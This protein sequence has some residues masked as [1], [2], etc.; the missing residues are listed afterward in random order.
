MNKP[1]ECPP[2]QPRLSDVEL[3]RSALDGKLKA[4]AGYDDILWK[5]R[6]GY[7][8]ILYGSLALIIGTEGLP[9]QAIARDFRSPLS[10][11]ILIIGFS[12]AAFFVDFGYLRKKLKVVVLTNSLISKASGSVSWNCKPSLESH[13]HISGE[14]NIKNSEFFPR[15]TLYKE[16]QR[17][18]NW[19]LLW[20]HL[21]LYASAPLITFIVY[22]L[23]RS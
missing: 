20:I 21:P 16:Y 6:A 12:L 22:L 14:A 5:I 1:N 10:I 9:L 4:I 13:L 19:N 8:A 15:Q 2:S 17:Q 11:M 23:N 7:A 3:V 18:R